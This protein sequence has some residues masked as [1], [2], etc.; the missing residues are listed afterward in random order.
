M[1]RP[2]PDILIQKDIGNNTWQVL[3]ANGCFVITYQDQPINVRVVYFTAQGETV[4]YQ[5]LTYANLGN[6]LAQVRT[7]NHRFNCEDF[8][9]MQVDFAGLD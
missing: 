2:K 6:A 1:G 3:K 8:A 7:L 5:K 9:V 4:K